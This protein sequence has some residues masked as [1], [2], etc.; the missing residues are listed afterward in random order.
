MVLFACGPRDRF[1]G[2]PLEMEL[3]AQQQVWADFC[4]EEQKYLRNRWAKPPTGE[5]L[6]ATVGNFDVFQ[7]SSYVEIRPRSAPS[8]S[9]NLGKPPSVKSGS[10]VSRVGTEY[11]SFQ[12]KRYGS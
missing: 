1:P 9:S 10:S 6:I 7:K 11:S 8:K 4:T 12:S 3:T 5:K 2:I